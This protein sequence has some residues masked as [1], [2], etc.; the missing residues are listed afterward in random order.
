MIPGGLPGIQ[1]APLEALLD[2]RQIDPAPAWH[3]VVPQVGLLQE[4][5]S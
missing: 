1:V 3:M 4:E 5:K 2:G